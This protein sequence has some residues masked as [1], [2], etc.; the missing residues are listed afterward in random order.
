MQHTG[1]ALREFL[2]TDAENAYTS[3]AVSAFAP[4]LLE[5]STTNCY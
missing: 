3:V 1:S 2:F 5:S 4:H